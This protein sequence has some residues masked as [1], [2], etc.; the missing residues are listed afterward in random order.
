MEM[1]PEAR[2]TM[3]DGIKKGEI[4]PG[5]PCTSFQCSRSI[6]SNQIGIGSTSA[7]ANGNVSRSEIDDGRRNKEGRNLAWT[8]LHKLPVLALDNVESDRNW[9]HERRSEW[10]C[11]Q[12]RD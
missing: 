11:F 3:A 1:F 9:V 4:L 6:M 10:K 8:A 5:P 2:L 12:K 7:V